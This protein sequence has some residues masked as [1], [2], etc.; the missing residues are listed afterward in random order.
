MLCRVG[1]KLLERQRGFGVRKQFFDQHSQQSSEIESY[2]PELGSRR[3]DQS[4]FLARVSGPAARFESVLTVADI[5]ASTCL[6][7][8]RENKRIGFAIFDEIEGDFFVS[9]SIN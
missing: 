5:N 6:C 4:W 8:Q 9:R 7:F 1:F 3:A 2:W